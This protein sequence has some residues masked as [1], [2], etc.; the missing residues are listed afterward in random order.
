M[1]QGASQA[2]LAAVTTAAGFSNCWR[3]VRYA[4]LFAA[5]IHVDDVI[6]A[7]LAHGLV[8][9]ALVSPAAAPLDVCDL[10]SVFFSA[11]PMPPSPKLPG[12]R[13]ASSAPTALETATSVGLCNWMYRFVF[14]GFLV[15]LAPSAGV[16]SDHPAVA[17]CPAC[18]AEHK[19]FSPTHFSAEKG[20]VVALQK[21]CHSKIWRESL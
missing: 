10:T 21:S 19:A 17:E 20:F 1:R 14:A 3:L 4:N 16:R 12:I 5:A 9:K 11:N 18:L 8:K 2:R 7:F 6:A 13:P 15:D